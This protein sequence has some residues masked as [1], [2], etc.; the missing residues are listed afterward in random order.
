MAF[1][2][3]ADHSGL[4]AS[5]A[6]NTQRPPPAAVRA[7]SLSLTGINVDDGMVNPA[8]GWKTIGYNLDDRCTTRASTDVCTLPQG[9]P[10]D[11]QVD[12]TAGIDNSFG[13]NICPLLASFGADPCSSQGS[14]IVVTD[15]TGTGT[16][17]IKLGPVGWLVVPVHD[18]YVLAGGSVNG[19]AAGTV[20]GVLPTESLVVAFQS[21]VGSISPSLCGGAGAAITQAVGQ[22]SDILSDGTNASGVTCDAVSFGLTFASS[23][24]F[25]GTLPSGTNA[26]AT[27]AAAE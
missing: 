25:S 8:N 7:A 16:L 10:R 5:A 2:C 4:D 13:E 3:C 19:M 12:G 9:S 18:T 20:A 17:A 21:Y 1:V 22:A 15:A 27:D 24:P 26:C 23:M 11:T 6:C 14:A